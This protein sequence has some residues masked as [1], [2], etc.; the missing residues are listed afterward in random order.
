MTKNVFQYLKKK[1]I[2]M[3]FTKFFNKVKTGEFHRALSKIE[4]NGI[5]V[6]LSSYIRL[7]KFF[8]II[9]LIYF[10]GF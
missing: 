2:T 4:F 9:W 8:H 5:I 6:S 3:I 1:R 7:V 10:T